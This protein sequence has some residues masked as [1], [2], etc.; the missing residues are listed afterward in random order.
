MKV[1]YRPVAKLIRESAKK[2][3]IDAV[4]QGRRPLPQSEWARRLGMSPA[5]YNNWLHGI[6][7]NPELMTLLKIS[8]YFKVPLPDLLGLDKEA[9]QCFVP[10]KH[11][12]GR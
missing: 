6:P 1:D 11:L 2:E 10:H 8:A 9:Y 4:K 5:A 3:K 12:K 7:R